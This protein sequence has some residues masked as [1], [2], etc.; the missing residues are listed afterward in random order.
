MRGRRRALVA[1]AVVIV[2]LLVPTGRAFAAGPAAPA[3]TGAG[4]PVD[5]R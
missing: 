3:P 5:A 2:T 4:A 1:V